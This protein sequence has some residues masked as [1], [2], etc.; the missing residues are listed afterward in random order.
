MFNTPFGDGIAELFCSNEAILFISPTRRRA[1]KK[2]PVGFSL[3][4][5]Q[6]ILQRLQTYCS[7]IFTGEDQDRG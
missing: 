2:C 4:Q 3:M 5:N 1:T 6:G 7:S